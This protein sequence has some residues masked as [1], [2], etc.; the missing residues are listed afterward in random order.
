MRGASV[1]LNIDFIAM[2]ELA[3]CYFNCVRRYYRYVAVT[4]IIVKH[5]NLKYSLRTINHS[6]GR[7]VAPPS[8]FC[9]DT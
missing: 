7:Q 4:T 5:G 1:V 2:N 6:Y 9:E 3:D 8:S